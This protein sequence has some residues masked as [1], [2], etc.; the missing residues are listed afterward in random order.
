MLPLSY[1]TTTEVM[2]F[3]SQ[4]YPA[5]T[6]NHLVNVIRQMDRLLSEERAFMLCAARTME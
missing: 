1:A 3:L 2:F 6:N 5:F 4:L